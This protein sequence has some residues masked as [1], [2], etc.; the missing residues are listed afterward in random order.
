MNN[1]NEESLDHALTGLRRPAARLPSLPESTATS[2]GRNPRRRRLDRRR[3][4]SSTESPSAVG[5]APLHRQSGG[6]RR[7][8]GGGGCWLFLI[9]LAAALLLALVG[10]LIQFAGEEFVVP[11]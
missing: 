2:A 5:S 7:L 9:F 11:Y 8:P 3:D 4:F 6:R 1:S 10:E